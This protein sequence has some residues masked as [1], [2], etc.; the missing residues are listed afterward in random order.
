[1]ICVSCS[2][3]HQIKLE[4]NKTWLQGKQVQS[5]TQQEDEPSRGLGATL[6]L[7]FIDNDCPHYA[8]TQLSEKKIKN[9]SKLKVY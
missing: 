9:K 1:V 8:G 5:N 2:K 6:Y 4:E 3:L 7:L